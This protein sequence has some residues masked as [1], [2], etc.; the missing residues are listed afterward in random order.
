MAGVVVG[1][2]D[3]RVEVVGVF[4]LG[5]A[6]GAAE[7]GHRGNV[8]RGLI[9]LGG[10]D[11]HGEGADEDLIV[12]AVGG[13][14]FAVE[15]ALGVEGG[16]GLEVRGKGIRRGGGRGFKRRGGNGGDDEGFLVA[17]DGGEE[18]PG[19]DGGRAVEPDAAAGE[20]DGGD[21]VIEDG[22]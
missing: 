16:G 11:A 1:E 15:L 8:L 19:R 4:E 22:G 5:V 21:D 9:P 6:G 13:D 18:A 20:V 3:G 7:A 17:D 14:N 12:V 10:G 2:D